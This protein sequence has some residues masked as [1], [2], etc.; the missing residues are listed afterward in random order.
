M[1]TSGDPAPA[2]GDPAPPGRDAAGPAATTVV[3][4]GVSGFLGQA[5]LRRLA[6]SVA[7]GRL[8]GLDVREPGYRPRS[9][10]FHLVD[11]AGSDLRPH[12]E[13]ADVLVHLAGVH[14][15]IPDEDLMARVNVGG[16][17]RVLEA[18]GAAGLGKVVLV[19]SAAVY[20]AWPNNPVPLTEDA[21][22]RPNPGFPLGVHKAE[23]ERLLAEWALARPA[24]VTTV[25]R[26]AFV[27]GARADHAVARLIRARVPLAVGGSTAPVQFVHEDDATE[28]IALAVERDLP[29]VYNVAADGWLSREELRAL[30]GR[31]VQPQV[32]PELMERA[33]RRLFNAGLVDVPPSEVPY[34]VHPWVVANDRLRAEGWAP[35]HTNAETVLACLGGREPGSAWKATVTAAA[36]AGLATTGL[37]VAGLLRRRRRRSG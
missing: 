14:D 37:V 15:A 5:V 16:T 3:I 22:L 28:A 31:K 9:L 36:G 6:G 1:K 12:F 23:L 35:S 10:Q 18:A 20:G 13:G 4:T 24:V 25:L 7:V 19:S 26:P 29:G 30:V 11:V 34:L 17:R 21:P 2:L 32:G 8:V 33:L 27:L